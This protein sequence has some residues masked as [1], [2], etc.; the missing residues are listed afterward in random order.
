M[1]LP[2]VITR[3]GAS[4]R[5]KSCRW[6]EAWKVTLRSRSIKSR[7]CWLIASLSFLKLPVITEKYSCSYVSL[8]AGSDAAQLA[9]RNRLQSTQAVI[10]GGEI[11]IDTRCATLAP[12][13]RLFDATERHR[14]AGHFDG[15]D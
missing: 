1:P 10:L 6:L 12:Q 11:F 2:P 9:P 15:V 14:R 7:C 4:P 3:P 13:P 5:A 8:K